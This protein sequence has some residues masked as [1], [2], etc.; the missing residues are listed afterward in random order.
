MCLALPVKIET[1]LDDEQAIV[2]LSGV[3]TKISTALVEDVH[4][5]DYVILHV[6]YALNKLDE[7]E[8]KRTLALFAQ[9]ETD[10]R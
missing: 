5:G 8:A 2:E 1:L 3:K 4:V 9:G 7:E 6:G 10:E